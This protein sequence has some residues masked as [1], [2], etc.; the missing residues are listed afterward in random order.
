[1]IPRRCDGGKRRQARGEKLLFY[2]QMTQMTQIVL[3]CVVQ[4]N[5][6]HSGRNVKG[7]KNIL[8]AK[9]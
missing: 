3:G 8:Q 9:A 6:P 4:E 1:M 2:P 5:Q 7:A